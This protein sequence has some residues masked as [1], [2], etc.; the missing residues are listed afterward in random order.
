[1]ER[2][3][4]MNLFNQVA[5]TVCFTVMGAM[6]GL[7]QGVES[8]VNASTGV[9]YVLVKEKVD[10]ATAE[11]RAAAMGGYLWCIAN[12]AEWRLLK[13]AFRFPRTEPIHTAL[14]QNS[15]GREPAEGWYWNCGFAGIRSTGYAPFNG[16]R[17][18]KPFPLGC[19]DD[20]AH[21]NGWDVY[22]GDGFIQVSW[23][24]N[25]GKNED[26]AV[27][28]TDNNGYLEDVSLNHK[29]WFIVEIPSKR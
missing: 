7:A 6:T 16:V 12:E 20:G 28:W 3:R 1:M 9:R 13:S 19:P 24:P 4:S 15:T 18:C 8:T 27:V 17:T 29:A 10:R 26:A 11:K 21:G 2:E 22:F 14:R 23:G 5:A 25:S